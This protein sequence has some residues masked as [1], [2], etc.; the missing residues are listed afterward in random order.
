M[1]QNTLKLAIDDLND[2]IKKLQEKE[3]K[4]YNAIEELQEKCKH[5]FEI[6]GNIGDV[7]LKCKYCRKK[8]IIG[9]VDFN[10]TKS[11]SD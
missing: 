11:K 7:G 1:D 10:H 9:T 2:K 8:E 4:Y 3:N 5:E 6:N